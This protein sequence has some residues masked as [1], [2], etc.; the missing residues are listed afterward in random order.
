MEE[1]GLTSGLIMVTKN[2]ID[3]IEK[4]VK[5]AA[6][7]PAKVERAKQRYGELRGRRT[8]ELEQWHDWNTSG[9]PTHKLEPLLKSVDPLIRSEAKKRMAGLGGS[10][11]MPAM[12]QELRNAA[13]IAIHNFD[14]GRGTQL[15]TH[16]VNNFQRITDFIAA[17]RN[18]KYMPREDVERFGAYSNAVNEFKEEHGR[19]PTV[20]ELQQKLP[21]LTIRQ[22]RKM[23]VGF[24]PEAFTDMGTEL[25]HDTGVEDPMQRI[26]GALLLMKSQ[27]TEEQRRFAEMHYPPEGGKQMSVT[28]IAKAMKIP[29][30]KAY[31][32]KKRVEAQLAPVVR[33]A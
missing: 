15:T 28:A 16:I 10:I 1:L 24:G 22:L 12:R 2:D 23:R 30:H 3:L 18:P 8:K 29:E 11:S 21:H 27:L 5:D 6:S 26:R 4:F 31:R 14:P 25:E 33:G 9:R 32:I 17:N 7:S 19:E 13:T 20:E